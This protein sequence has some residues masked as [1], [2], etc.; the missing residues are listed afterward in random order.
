M[1]IKDCFH[2]LCKYPSL[3]S[4]WCNSIPAIPYRHCIVKFVS[5]AHFSASCPDLSTPDAD[6]VNPGVTLRFT[7]LVFA[8]R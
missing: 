3:S 6:L 5:V 8:V 7:S 4:H 2:I 1:G